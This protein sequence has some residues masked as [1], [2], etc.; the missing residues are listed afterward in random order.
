M[1]VPPGS[2][3]VIVEDDVDLLHALKFALELE[4]W[5]VVIYETAELLL[6]GTSLPSKGCLVLDQILPGTSGL[7]LLMELRARGSTMP[8]IIITTNPGEQLKRRIAKAG[9]IIVEK[10][11]LGST[12]IDAIRS[13]LALPDGS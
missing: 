10:P 8:A 1:L 2:T 13:A 5:A 4:G 7:D 6:Q 11:L 3:V 12:L 9:A